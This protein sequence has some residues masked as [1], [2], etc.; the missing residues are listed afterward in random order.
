MELDLCFVWER[1]QNGQVIVNFVPNP[2]HLLIFKTTMTSILVDC[3]LH[4]PL[5]VTRIPL[6]L[7]VIIF[8]S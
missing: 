8:F 6:I 1:V 4:L 7:I 3:F 2:N 5:V